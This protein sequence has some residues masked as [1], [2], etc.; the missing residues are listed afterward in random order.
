MS[1]AT[2]SDDRKEFVVHTTG[3]YTGALELRFASDCVDDLIAALTSARGDAHPAAPDAAQPA[4]AP[5]VV[6]NPN[7]AEAVAP[8]VPSKDNPD[9]VKF[10]IPKN[11]TISADNSG[12]GLVLFIL[13][14]RLERQA[15]YAFTPDA[16]KQ[17]AG[18]LTK[19]AD[20][21]LARQAAPKT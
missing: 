17:L 1:S 6:R 9:E 16:A 20:A 5:A 4:A 14:H 13:N 21:L 15:G 12:R 11:C 19:S 8:A 18:G 10:E 2:M 3:K 7:G